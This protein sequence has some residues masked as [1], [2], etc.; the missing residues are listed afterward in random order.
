M[1]KFIILDIKTSKIKFLVFL[2]CK[3]SSH[4]FNQL[5]IKSKNTCT[6]KKTIFMIFLIC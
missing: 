6:N 5:V 1:Y 4:S 3:L 2:K